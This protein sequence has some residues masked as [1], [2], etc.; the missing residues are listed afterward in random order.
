MLC[1]GR[2]DY[3]GLVLREETCKIFGVS[4]CQ[5]FFS[6]YEAH[7]AEQCSESCQLLHISVKHLY[8]S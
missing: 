7:D 8:D 2:V 4:N 6:N 1:G 5:Y 3:V